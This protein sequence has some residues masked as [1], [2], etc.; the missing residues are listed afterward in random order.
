MD[1][2]VVLALGIQC[3]RDRDWRKGL[4]AAGHA[5]GSLGWEAP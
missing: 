1:K 4:A 3:W 2:E 5:V